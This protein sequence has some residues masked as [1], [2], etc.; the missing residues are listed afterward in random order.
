MAKQ[1][2]ID[3]LRNIG[4]DATRK[5]VHKPFSE[6][7]C[8]LYLMQMGAILSL[9]PPPP[10]RLLDVGCGTGWTSAFYARR[11]YTVVGVDISPDMIHH[12]RMMKERE[13]LDNLEFVVGDYED[14]AFAGE[15]DCAVFYD[16]LHHAL[17]EEA[18]VG[19]AYRAL[20]PGGTCVT[21]EPG[22]GHAR[23][24]DS[25][26]AVKKYNVTERDMPP[27]A[28]VAAGRKAGFRR[29]RVYPQAW[30]LGSATYAYTGRV[31]QS[32]AQKWEWV[33]RLGSAA[34]VLRLV[35]YRS[36]DSGIV[37]MVK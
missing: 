29:F 16:A 21:S 22:K 26:E 12:A 17:D 35:L 15:F 18:A 7:N 4:A 10:A 23:H 36:R 8:H 37:V 9:L 32:L 28:I 11:G 24:P 27:A 20:K 25:L 2:E 34:L 6:P 5:A 30:E 13:G 19:M 3:Y 31:L 33:R 14:L 1:G